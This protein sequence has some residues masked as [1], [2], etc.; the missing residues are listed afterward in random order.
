METEAAAR[1]RLFCKR[2]NVV[3][4]KTDNHFKRREIATKTEALFNALLPMKVVGI[5]KPA[6]SVIVLTLLSRLQ[7]P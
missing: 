7:S 6:P 5:R 3:C 4:H 2:F 1:N